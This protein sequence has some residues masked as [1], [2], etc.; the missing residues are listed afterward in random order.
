MKLVERRG[1]VGGHQV[2]NLMAPDAG[3]SLIV[4]T[5]QAKLD[6]GELWQGRG[7]GHDLAAA[8]FCPQPTPSPHSP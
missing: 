3:I 4:F 1:N 2:R 6:F 8:A 5:N 7:L